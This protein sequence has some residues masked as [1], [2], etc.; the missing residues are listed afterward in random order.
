MSK[1]I[2]NIIVNVDIVDDDGNTIRT[3]TLEWDSEDDKDPTLSQSQIKNIVDY[4]CE[5]IDVLKE[6][7]Y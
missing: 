7:K 2:T 4:L 6:E 1:F 5:F 3:E